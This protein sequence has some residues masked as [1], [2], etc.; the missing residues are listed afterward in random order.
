MRSGVAAVQNTLTPPA[1]NVLRLAIHNAQQRGHTHVQ[2]LHVALALLSQG[3]P[4]LRRACADIHTQAAHGL[5]QC[6]A[7]D[8]CFNVALDRLPQSSSSSNTHPIALSNALVA[9]LKRAQA[10]QKRGCPEQQQPPLVAVKVEIE[11]LIISILEDPSVSRVM[12]E[13]GFVSQDVKTN[14]ENAISLSSSLQQSRDN[15][16]SPRSL[17]TDL[18]PPL[19]GCV[20]VRPSMLPSPWSM[21]ASTEDSKV[22][23]CRE[24]MS[25]LNAECEQ[26]RVQEGAQVEAV[27][28]SLP[29]WLQKEKDKSEQ[30][31]CQSLARKVQE[32]QQRWQVFCRTSHSTRDM[33]HGLLPLHSRMESNIS[34]NTEAFG[35]MGAK[36]TPTLSPAMNRSHWTCS[37]PTIPLTA[38][39][40]GFRAVYSDAIGSK[41]QGLENMATLMSEDS[42]KKIDASQ[43]GLSK[44]LEQGRPQPSPS[45]FARLH[46]N[47]SKSPTSGCP[48]Q[49][50]PLS[51]PSPLSRLHGSG[52]KS[53]TSGCPLQSSSLSSPSPLLRLHGNEPKL[54]T[55]GCPLQSSPLSN[56]LSAL[57]TSKPLLNPSSLMAKTPSP[58]M[59]KSPSPLMAKSP[60]S[61]MAKSPSPLMAKSPSPLMAR[62]P[63]P[64]MAKSPLAQLQH[65]SK[66]MSPLSEPSLKK[67]SKPLALFD[68]K[69]AERLK[70]VYRGVL[71]RVS[72]QSNAVSEIT[73][74]LVNIQSG[75]GKSQGVLAARADTWLLLLGPDQV[76]KRLIAE[77]LADLIG[78]GKKPVCFGLIQDGTFSRWGR[79]DEQK[80]PRGPSTL[81]SLAETF[82]TNPCAVLLLEDIDQADTVLRTKLANAME[83]GKFMDSSARQVNMG[84]AIV[85]MTSKL[86]TQ[87]IKDS[88]FQE[89]NVSSLP[90]A[91]M[92]LTLELPENKEVI[93]LGDHNVRV[94][95]D[96]TSDPEALDRSTVN[97]L[98]PLKRK[99]AGELLMQEKRPKLAV[100]LDLNL[101]AKENEESGCSSQE[102]KAS[103]SD[104]VL[105]AA[106]QVL[107]PRFLNLVDNVVVFEPFNMMEQANWILLQLSNACS[108]LNVEVDFQLLNHMIS[109]LWQTPGGRLAFETWIQKNL[110]SRLSAFAND[111]IGD[112]VLRFVYQDS[113]S[114]SP[115]EL[116]LQIELGNR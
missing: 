40:E 65:P 89:E 34:I 51:S 63:S 2:P 77:A 90:G 82:R 36:S 39:S 97:F 27:G 95:K 85:L 83:T 69:A 105:T 22:L 1:Q 113:F 43:L 30:E 33:A 48:L 93:F 28:S 38:I 98:A 109:A 21:R 3:G 5:Q 46:G 44:P 61:L 111:V 13:A 68:Q 60:S 112:R 12:K 19:A 79:K 29:S 78:K 64:L 14:L 87:D 81:D 71:D 102:S 57:K 92:K 91:R 10:H 42:S 55:S 110:K 49:S 37:L 50:S 88:P 6:H 100:S 54:L 7:L 52:P 58:L 114:G 18:E 53:P 45:P 73:T 96:A 59:A 94:V 70:H 41:P 4:L 101:S 35:F 62:S 99:P 103:E 104:P 66:G 76:G 31:K 11:Q 107:S 72:W 108:G 106:K 116:P 56:P 47:V 16:H 26:L 9:A 17:P 20:G 86:G 74:A 25:Q 115:S 84:N 80:L 67:D 15:H 32:I 23:C 8:L 75:M 24:C